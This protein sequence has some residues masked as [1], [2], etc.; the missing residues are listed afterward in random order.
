MSHEDVETQQHGSYGPY[1]RSILRQAGALSEEHTVL[2]NGEHTMM[3]VRKEVIDVNPE[4]TARLADLLSNM[5]LDIR[6][7]TVIGA[8]ETSTS[9]S[10]RVA[11]HLIA[12]TS[13][14]L[15]SVM[16]HQFSAPGV[17]DFVTIPE[18]YEP[19]IRG[20]RVIIIVQIVTTG[21]GVAALHNAVV[22]MGGTP[23]AIGL[24]WNRHSVAL[25][26][27]SL[28]VRMLVEEPIHTWS[29]GSCPYCRGEYKTRAKS[30]VA[31]ICPPPERA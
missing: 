6:A 27:G 1:V 10:H 11:E 29:A 18:I 25:V 12:K 20:R 3:Y 7:D 5:L 13:K 23:V 2:S 14:T 17:G 4:T 30:W 21:G 15:W 22:A 16:A 28:P 24:L 19:Y 9:F 8:G 31:Q 26:D